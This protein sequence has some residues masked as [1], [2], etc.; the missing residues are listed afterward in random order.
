MYSLA[1][2]GSSGRI[3][4]LLLNFIRNSANFTLYSAIVAADEGLEGKD[5]SE[6]TGGEAT[7]VQCSSKVDFSHGHC[8]LLIDFSHPSATQLC[9]AACLEAQV[10]LVIGTTGHTTEQQEAIKEAA[11]S[12][13]IL[14]AAN[15]SLGVNLCLS[16]VRQAVTAL[17]DDYDIEINE[18]HH[19]YKI[20]APSG[21]A[22]ALAEVAAA[23][24]GK[25]LADLAVYDRTQKRA[26]R[27]QGTIGFQVVRGGDLI[28][29]HRVQLITEGET[30]EICHKARSRSIFVNGAIEAGQWLIKQEKP[31][32]YSMAD[33][34]KL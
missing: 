15:M 27:Q 18:A 4:R 14:Q 8:D 19:K 34:L 16:L 23:A 24:R 29:E 22:L 9:V 26:A 20:D 32:L 10:P 21:T 1:I 11:N 5:A 28:G 12:L 3:G 7:G 2:C 25:A 33:L 17:N 31:G 6:I 13:P 30:I